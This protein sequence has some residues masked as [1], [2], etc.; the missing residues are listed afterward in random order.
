[1]ILLLKRFLRTPGILLAVG[2]ATL[3]TGWLDLSG[4]FGVGVMGVMPRGL[5]SF[6]FPAFDLQE[7]GGLCQAAIAIAVV[8]FAD[9]SVLSRV[10]A[11]KTRV[12]VDPNRE[13][14]GLG[15]AN[16]AA[17]FFRG[18]PVSSSSSRTPVAEASGSKTQL[19]GVVGALAIALM[20]VFAPGLLRN[21]PM[22]RSRRS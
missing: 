14:M 17:G 3:L 13:M 9:T 15:M 7:I 21:L 12:H 11:A 2:G 22:P 4:R 16:L 6:A 8:S 20:L 18:F 5:P 19:T 10:Y 1:V